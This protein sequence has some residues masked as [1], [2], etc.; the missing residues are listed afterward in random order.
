MNCAKCQRELERHETVY[1]VWRRDDFNGR[2]VSIFGGFNALPICS[3]CIDESN[4]RD[5][6]PCERCG[7][8][9][10]NEAGRPAPK[11][12]VCSRACQNG[13]YNARAWQRRKQARMRARKKSVCA[14]CAK[15][16]ILARDDAQYCSNRCR[17]LAYRKRQANISASTAA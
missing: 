11:I 16:F 15:P 13:A 10:I 17:Q 6:C 7:R 1:R 12:V 3:L 9:V 8:P 14:Q 4:W 5:P 2:Y